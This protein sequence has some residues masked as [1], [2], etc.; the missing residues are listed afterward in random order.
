V[1]PQ[2]EALQVAPEPLRPKL[3]RAQQKKKRM[4]AQRPVTASSSSTTHGVGV[5]VRRS[6]NNP[7]KAEYE[8]EFNFQPQI[9]EYKTHRARKGIEQRIDEWTNA[10]AVSRREARRQEQ[11]QLKEQERMK[12]CTFVPTTNTKEKEHASGN[13]THNV[14]QPASERLYAQAS[15]RVLLEQMSKEEAEALKMAEC[16]FQPQL[17][18][19]SSA[20]RANSKADDMYQRSLAW[21]S[22]KQQHIF[23]LKGVH[24]LNPEHTFKPSLCKHSAVLLKQ[25][26][27]LAAQQEQQARL[28]EKKKTAKKKHEHEPTHTPSINPNSLAILAKS[29]LLKEKSFEERRVAFLAA[30]DAKQEA[31]RQQVLQNED[32]TFAPDIGKSGSVVA[33]SKLRHV[34]HEQETDAERSERLAYGA[35]RMTKVHTFVVLFC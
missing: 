15:R 25:R 28:E 2:P 34:F 17:N 31:L 7:Y 9:T 3:T 32:C 10:A 11:W 14:A 21:Q 33:Q 18:A 20:L 23:E 35:S 12:E 22:Q 27:T 30:R 8:R 29:D 5:S 4:K 19:R 24:E 16:S 1:A 13:T 6:H 26:T